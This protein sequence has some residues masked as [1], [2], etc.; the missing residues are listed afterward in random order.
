M[1]YELLSS[2]SFLFLLPK[3]AVSI[4]AAEMSYHFGSLVLA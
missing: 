2:G 3:A 4:R 1:V